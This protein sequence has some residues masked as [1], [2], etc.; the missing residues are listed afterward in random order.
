MWFYW[1]SIDFQLPLCDYQSNRLTNL[2]LFLL[3][4]HIGVPPHSATRHGSV[5]SSWPLP[6]WGFPFSILCPTFAARCYFRRPLLHCPWGFHSSA[7]RAMLPSSLLQV[8][9][10]HFHFLLLM[11]LVIASCW[12]IC[13]SYSIDILSGQKMLRICLRHLIMKTWSFWSRAFVHFHDSDL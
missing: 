3:R 4:W 8:W 5:L 13:Q 12:V 10:T 11:V 9:P 2:I 6:R 1:H 7:V